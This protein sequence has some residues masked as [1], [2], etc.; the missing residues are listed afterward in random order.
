MDRDLMDLRKRMIGSSIE[1]IRAQRVLLKAVAPNT[2]R[3]ATELREVAE[4]YLK[5]AEP[6]GAALQ[7]LR[8][9]LLAAEPSAMVDVELD[10]MDRL[11]N[12][13]DK[14]KKVGLKLITHQLYKRSQLGRYR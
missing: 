12:A 1:F 8:E 11:I 4:E 5:A 6:Y 7:E 14:E 2:R 10:H 9:Y 3:S 13:L